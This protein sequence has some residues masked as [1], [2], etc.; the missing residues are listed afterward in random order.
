MLIVFRVDIQQFLAVL[1]IFFGIELN[2]QNST[3][4]VSELGTELIFNGYAEAYYSYDAGDP[5]GGQKPDFL[6]NHSNHNSPAF[7]LMFL[8]AALINPKWRANV[9][10]MGG[11]YSVYNLAQEPGLLRHVFEAN[12]GLRLSKCY[13]IWLDA[14]ILPS[15][16]GFESAVGGDCWTLTRSIVAENSPYYE[17]GIKLSSGLLEEKLTVALLALTGWQRM[18]PAEGNKLPSAG[19]QLNYKPSE[20]W[21]LNYSGFA[22]NVN[23]DIKKH[24]RHYHNLYVIYEKDRYGV[25]GGIDFGFQNNTDS[26]GTSLKKGFW[27]TPVIIARMKAAKNLHFALRGEYFNDSNAFMT[28]SFSANGLS[29]IGV[30][31]NTDVIINSFF[32]LRFEGRMFKDANSVFSYKHKPSAENLSLTTSIIVRF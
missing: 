3:D 12:A 26:S 14:G 6:Y 27:Y 4:T 13:N 5:P 16:I 20:Y 19:W 24:F 22:G 23:T 2:A 28:E 1:I 30:S 8:K 9:A 32:K 18:L 31:F 15:H 11:T 25:I 7:N 21:Q 10:V 17:S 29:T